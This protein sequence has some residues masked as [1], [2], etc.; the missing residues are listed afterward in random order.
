[1]V[2]RSVG[3]LVG[4]A[5]GLLSVNEDEHREH[6]EGSSSRDKEQRDQ[7]NGSWYEEPESGTKKIDRSIDSSTKEDETSS[8][9]I[10]DHPSCRQKAIK[11]TDS[12]VYYDAKLSKNGETR[13]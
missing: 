12:G 8:A 4:R 11:G 6:M 10:K 5:E 3:R 1:M 13:K 9:P 7:L 2:V